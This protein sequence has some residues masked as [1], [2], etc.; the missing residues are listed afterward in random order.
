[1]PHRA[2]HEGEHAVNCP[3][4]ITLAEK[5]RMP[6]HKD[7]R[8]VI[9]RQPEFQRQ[10]DKAVKRR[11][12]PAK[13]ERCV[14]AVKGRK[15]V[16]SAYAIC[17]A[18]MK[19]AAVIIRLRWTSFHDGMQYL[20]CTKEDLARRVGKLI[21]DEIPFTITDRNGKV[22]GKYTPP[23]PPPLTGRKR[24]PGFQGPSQWYIHIQRYA[25]NRGIGP[26]M[27]YNGKSFSDR[28]DSKPY[29]FS[30]KTAAASMARRLV[31]NNQ[32]L[33]PYKVWIAPALY[34]QNSV[35]RTI[36]PQ[37]RRVCS[38][39]GE[40]V[41]PGTH[42][43]KVKVCFHGENGKPSRHAGPFVSPTAWGQGV[44]A[45]MSR[46]KNPA[47]ASV[48]LDEAAQKL[49]EF[50][51]RPAGDVI[52]SEPR[53]KDKTGLVIGELDL[54]GYRQARE[55]IDGGRMTRFAHKFRKNSR[56]LLAVSTDGKQLHIVGGQY[57][58]TDAGI[59]DR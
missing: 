43:S 35:E 53:S 54:I 7:Y 52:Q 26:V 27:I 45:G 16:R 19:N 9:A 31:T 44:W 14:K 12:N 55:G 11:K 29:G 6:W 15:G 46:R 10:H 18:A 36:N 41:K 42:A 47:P 40:M 1:M 51:G 48:S 57:E 22:V 37:R 21:A 39:C 4:C 23:R 58:F 24:N 8:D 59:E 5:A 32:K 33:A 38:A 13:L 3:A 49:E 20:D 56:P 50:T 34:G 2:K 17:T 28:P 25:G 30:S